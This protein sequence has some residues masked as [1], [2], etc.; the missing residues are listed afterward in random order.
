MNRPIVYTMLKTIKEEDY[1]EENDYFSDTLYNL[2]DPKT[3]NKLI[4]NDLELVDIK[5]TPITDEEGKKLLTF[6]FL[7]SEVYKENLQF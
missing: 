5:I 2:S 6:L 4:G 7:Y 3:V 1:H